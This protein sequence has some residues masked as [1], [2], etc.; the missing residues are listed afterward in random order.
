MWGPPGYP[1][2]FVSHELVPGSRSTYYKTSPE[3]EKFGG[4]WAI[5]AVDAPNAFT[6]EPFDGGTRA[7][8]V[9]AYD[10]AD[11]LQ[12]VLEMGID[13]GARLAINQIDDLLAA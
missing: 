11:A 4:W 2:T 10:S 3:G 12:K 6:F 1:A 13:Q 7:I 5:A 9:S 8:F